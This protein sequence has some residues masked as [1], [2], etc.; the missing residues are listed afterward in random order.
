MAATR[1]VMTQNDGSVARTDD[2]GLLGRDLPY[3]P[4]QH[5]GVV[6][7][8]RTHDG[9]LVGPLE[10]VGG[11]PCAADADLDDG[12]VDSFAGEGP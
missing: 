12:V 7:P 8:D 10:N 6:E 5:L 2:P 3:R 1:S 9:H 11:V 4:A